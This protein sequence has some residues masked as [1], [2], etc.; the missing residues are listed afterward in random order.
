M[1][2]VLTKGL[3]LT[4]KVRVLIDKGAEVIRTV[5]AS[6]SNL[7]DNKVLVCVVLNFNP[8]SETAFVIRDQKE[9]NKFSIV[10][11]SNPQPKTWLLIDKKVVKEFE[12]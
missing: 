8:F 1:D 2:S 4:G 11:L 12:E 10:N 7:P 6:I 9:L 5:P 3:K